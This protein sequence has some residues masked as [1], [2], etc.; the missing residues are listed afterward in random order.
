MQVHAQWHRVTGGGYNITS[1]MDLKAVKDIVAAMT[2]L[3]KASRDLPGLQ[4]SADPQRYPPMELLIFARRRDFNRIVKRPI[5]SAFTQPGLRQTLLVVGPSRG[6][7]RESALHEYIHYLFRQQATNQPPWYE[8]GLATLLGQSRF[9]FDEAEAQVTVRLPDPG[10]AL[11]L[12]ASE[13]LDVRAYIDLPSKR[14][15]AFYR[16][17]AELVNFLL[18]ARSKRWPDYRMGLAEYLASRDFDAWSQDRFT[19]SDLNRHAAAF[20]QRRDEVSA[21]LRV[22]HEPMQLETTPID[23]AEAEALMAHAAELVNPEQAAEL[24]SR[25][26]RNQPTD[27]ELHSG[28]IRSL[29]S[30]DSAA[31]VT[32]LNQARAAVPAAPELLLSEVSI[33]T[34][35]C[36]LQAD[37]D[38]RQQWRR[39]TEL[40]RQ[41]LAKLPDRIDAVMLLG[42]AELY[43]GRPGRAINYLR[44]A[45]QRVPWSPIVNFYFGECQRLLGM[46][47]AAQHL[48]NARDWALQP[49]VRKLAEASL[50]KLASHGNPLSTDAE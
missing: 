39:A 1:D 18:F 2:A 11:M 34:R 49:F 24:Y 23:R 19:R 3:Q 32:A 7:A 33:I 10:Q 47:G 22:P 4:A 6:S 26:L 25:L 27:V 8:E 41:V 48:Q 46:S 28:L 5:F 37:V 31:A 43:S 45:H 12:P 44:A 16:S 9:R 50:E 29:L 15:L 38:C 35:Q 13:L 20:Q 30:F 36:V 14:L 40:L 42:V 21:R 17:S